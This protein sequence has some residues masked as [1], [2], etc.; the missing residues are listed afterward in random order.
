[1]ECG[2]DL[3]QLPS[4]ARGNKI[5]DE[6]TKWAGKCGFLRL[7]VSIPYLFRFNPCFQYFARGKFKNC[8]LF[9]PSSVSLFFPFSNNK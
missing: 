8:S 3:F 4:T 7:L 2:Q 5:I 9:F 1:L 6:K